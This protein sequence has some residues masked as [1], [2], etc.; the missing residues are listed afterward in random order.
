[1][2]SR[3]LPGA[4]LKNWAAFSSVVRPWRVSSRDTLPTVASMRRTPEA[5]LLSDLMRNIPALAVLSRWVPPHSSME[6]SPM[7]TTRTVSPYFSPKVATAPRALAS[8]SGSSSVVTGRPSSTASFTRS[9]TCR[10]CSGVM[11]SK[12]VK[13]K[14][15]RSGS[16]SEPA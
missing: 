10:I 4:V 6:N 15:R 8:A 3:M 2:R 16:T 9:S 11:A 12:W 14:R 5:T 13:S 7:V 1:M